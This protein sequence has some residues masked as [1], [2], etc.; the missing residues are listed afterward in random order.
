MVENPNPKIRI[1]YGRGKNPNEGFT[2]LKA[3]CTDD[4]A[5]PCGSAAESSLCGA[6]QKVY[7]LVIKAFGSYKV[8]SH[9]KGWCYVFNSWLMKSNVRKS[10]QSVYKKKVCVRS[11]S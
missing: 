8:G 9:K 4:V 2:T 5:V 10:T 3:H 7:V 1:L 11:S 6:S